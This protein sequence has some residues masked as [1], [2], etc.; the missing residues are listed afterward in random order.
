MATPTYFSATVMAEEKPGEHKHEEGEH[1]HEAGEKLKLGEATLNGTIFTV[2][3]NGHLHAGEECD[4][5][6]TT[7]GELPAGVLRGWIGDESGKGSVKGKAHKEGDGLCVHAEAP[8]PIPA[9]AKIWIEL[10]VDGK[11]SKAS[12]ALPKH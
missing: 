5:K 6:L 11:K 7:K 4:I 9:E 2:E 1:K 8:N 10:E 12:F 3:L